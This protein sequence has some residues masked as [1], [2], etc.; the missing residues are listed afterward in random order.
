VARQALRCD[1]DHIPIV[2]DGVPVGIVAQ[3]DLLPMV[4]AEAKSR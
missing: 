1:I 3:H 4:A 2:C